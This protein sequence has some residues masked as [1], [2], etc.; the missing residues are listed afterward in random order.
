MICIE[1]EVGVVMGALSGVGAALDAWVAGE[2]EFGPGSW[3]GIEL[4]FGPGSWTGVVA[5]FVLGLWAGI[6]VE[7]LLETG[8]VDVDALFG[9][10]ECTGWMG[11]EKG[12]TEVEQAVTG[13]SEGMPGSDCGFGVVVGT[14]VGARHAW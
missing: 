4:A 8:F 2:V 1:S 3:T 7:V 11:T 10:V 6:E 9:A 14:L 5:Q 12:A 13:L